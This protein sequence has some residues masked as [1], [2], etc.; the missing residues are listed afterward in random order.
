MYHSLD[1]SPLAKDIYELRVKFRLTQ[2]EFAFRV[3]C[4]PNFVS[5]VERGRAKASVNMLNKIGDEFGY[6]VRL[7]PMS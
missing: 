2:R 7:M 1:T 6:Y 5:M 4:S 3:G